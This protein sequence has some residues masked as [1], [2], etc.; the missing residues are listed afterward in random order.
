[1]T[2]HFWLGM[3][4][5]F[6]SG[7]L[8][9]SFPLPMKYTRQWKWENTWLVFAAAALLIIPWLLAASFVPHLGDVYG[10]LPVRAL[11][12]P[13]IFGF[14]WGIAQVTF[15]LSIRAIGM[16]VAFAVV[17]GLQ[18]PVGSLTPLLVFHP[19]AL[20]R[21][22]GLLLL[23]SLPVLVLATLLGGVEPWTIVASFFITAGV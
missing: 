15:G 22:R 8:N 7:G 6:I 10:G 14:L 16:A 18:T 1:M 11:L 3:A 20:F 23:A 5:I 9:G 17:Q 2:D 4:V 12:A 13:L 19:A 21:P